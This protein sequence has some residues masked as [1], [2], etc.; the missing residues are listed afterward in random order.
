MPKRD[1]TKVALQNSFAF[2]GPIKYFES[3]PPDL[4]W[5]G[6]KNEQFFKSSL[7]LY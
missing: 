2:M 5:L 7:I 1:F 3:A 4:G 6:D